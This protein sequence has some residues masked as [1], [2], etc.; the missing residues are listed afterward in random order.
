MRGKQPEPSDLFPKRQNKEG[1]LRGLPVHRHVAAIRQLIEGVGAALL[2]GDATGPGPRP[3]QGPAGPF[4]LRLIS[5]VPADRAA[6]PG[7]AHRREFEPAALANAV[8]LKLTSAGRIRCE[9]RTHFVA[10]CGQNDPP[11]LGGPCKEEG[12]HQA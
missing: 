6:I 4:N 12:E 11:H 1:S 7:T 5:G 10:L 9:G 3:V 8:Y 2:E